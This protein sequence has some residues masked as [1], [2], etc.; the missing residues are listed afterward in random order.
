MS[1]A[2]KVLVV[3]V[4][5]T[6]IAWLVPFCMVAQL[7]RN[8]G[9]QVKKNAAELAKLE[10]DVTKTNED[11][12]KVKDDLAREQYVRNQNLIVLRTTIADHEKSLTARTET[13]ER[14]KN[15]VA[16][17]QQAEK[18]AATAAQRRVAEK[19]ETLKLKAA[20][21]DEVKKLTQENEKLTTQLT[22]LQQDFKNTLAENQRLIAR[23]GR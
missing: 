4:T 19:A 8:W 16:G 2:G 21:E 18:D 23:A 10:E 20:A 11:L 13:L 12:Q 17:Q 9:E 7:N 5:L 22:S 6:L 3:L 1:T 15:R 14:A